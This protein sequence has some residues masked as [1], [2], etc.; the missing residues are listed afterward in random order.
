[1][2]CAVYERPE[3]TKSGIVLADVTREEDQFQ[4]KVCLVVKLGPDAFVD[5]GSWEFR[6]KAQVGDWIWFRTSD[7]FALKIN[8]KLCRVIDDDKIKGTLPD[9][10]MVF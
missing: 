6:M 10:D 4:G 1:M 5:S 8:G 7:S 9:P 3:K 2:L